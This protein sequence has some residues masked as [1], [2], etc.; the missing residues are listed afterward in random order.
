MTY[1]EI[2]KHAAATVDEWFISNPKYFYDKA[3][4]IAERREAWKKEATRLN[5]KEQRLVTFRDPDSGIW[6]PDVTKHY[7]ERKEPSFIDPILFL[8][9]RYDVKEQQITVPVS[10]LT[11]DDALLV[12]YTALIILHDLRCC[13]TPI[14][15]GI[16]PDGLAEHIFDVYREDQPDESDKS[17][18]IETAL[19]HVQADLTAKKRR[20]NKRTDETPHKTK[21]KHS[22][23][24]GVKQWASI[25]GISKNK[26]RELR[27]SK[28]AYHFRKVSS[29]LWTLPENELPAEYLVKYRQAISYT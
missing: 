18:F 9:G 7:P 23:P 8:L 26:L 12:Y 27:D 16:W 29:R 14:T 24:L 3:R 19:R 20:S 1:D 17:E 21:I 22:L 25:F 15:K 4:L 5:P 10:E 2:K 6:Y 11:H 13:Y 28:K